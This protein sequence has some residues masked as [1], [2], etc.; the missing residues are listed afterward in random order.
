MVSLIARQVYTMW[1]V[2][3]YVMFLP[4]P[5]FICWHLFFEIEC[6]PST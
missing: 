4:S 3:P 6:I 5:G 1:L 2:L